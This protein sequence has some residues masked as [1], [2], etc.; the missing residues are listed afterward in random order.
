[1]SMIFIVILCSSPV[2]AEVSQVVDA[3][4][5]TESIVEDYLS[6]NRNSLELTGYNQIELNAAVALSNWTT[7][8]EIILDGL[9]DIDDEILATLVTW[10]PVSGLLKPPSVLSL[11]GLEK[12]STE[13]A[14]ML[15]QWNGSQILLDGVTTLDAKTLRQLNNWV[16][17]SCLRIFRIDCGLLSLN[18]LQELDFWQSS[19]L[20]NWENGDTLELNGIHTINFWN[21]YAL[22]NWVGQQFYL[23][24]VQDLS[25]V[26]ARNLAKWSGYALHL[27]GI[28]KLTPATA[29]ALSKWPPMS[30]FWRLILRIFPFKFINSELH[31]NGL[32]TLD[33]TTAKRLFSYKGDVLYLNGVQ[34][35]SPEVVSEIHSVEIQ[36]FL[37]GIEF[38]EKTP[39][40]LR[41]YCLLDDLQ[42]ILLWEY[43]PYEACEYLYIE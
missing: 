32:K 40:D 3:R 10:T 19:A 20:A 29:G 7:G 1:M 27:D 14:T 37:E 41:Q 13:Q 30:L 28:E 8:S 23:N 25:F 36:V 18:G 24:G 5:L 33:V 11:N 16:P 2:F 12:L 31:L 43:L 21:S 38:N 4:V 42:F 39:Q 17:E 15:A 34:Y 35:L 6:E 22:N 9:T 26:T